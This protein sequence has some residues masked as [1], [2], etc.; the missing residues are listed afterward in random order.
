MISQHY[1]TARDNLSIGSHLKTVLDPG[2]LLLWARLRFEY[3]NDDE[4]NSVNHARD[5]F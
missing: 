2:W 4:P 5:D 1:K 3:E